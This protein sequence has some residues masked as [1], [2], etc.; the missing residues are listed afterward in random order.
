MLE[1]LQGTIRNHAKK[2]Y[3]KV[4]NDEEACTN[5]QIKIGVLGGSVRM[6]RSFF[7]F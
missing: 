3:W 5:I 2:L 1:K 7:K 6:D 4:S